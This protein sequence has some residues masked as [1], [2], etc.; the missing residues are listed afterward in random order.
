MLD[1]KP[2]ETSILHVNNNSF[3]GPL[4]TGA[5]EKRAVWKQVRH[6]LVFLK[7]RVAHPQLRIPRRT[8]PPR[9]PPPALP[10]LN[11]SSASLHFSRYYANFECIRKSR[12]I[13]NWV[14]N[15]IDR[16]QLDHL[17]ITCGQ[18]RYLH[19]IGFLAV[20]CTDQDVGRGERDPSTW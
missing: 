1:I 8:P 14:E 3:T 7:N 9:V 16:L 12:A 5:F 17:R 4:I 19:E 11:Q 10:S 15:L 20:G 2:T 18:R 6:V 13:D